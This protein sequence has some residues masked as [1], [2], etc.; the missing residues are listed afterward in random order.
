LGA[1]TAKQHK[2]AVLQEALADEDD[3]SELLS[4]LNEEQDSDEP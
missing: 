1:K 2:T 4:S 3:S